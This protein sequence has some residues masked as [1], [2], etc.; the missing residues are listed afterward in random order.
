MI[1]LFVFMKLCTRYDI[2]TS[3]GKKYLFE[4]KTTRNGRIESGA[5]L[6]MSKLKSSAK[7]K[8]YT[9]K[10]FVCRT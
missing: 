3:I 2:N 6:R 9:F 8:K 1:Y 10:L 4:T 5:I 7:Y